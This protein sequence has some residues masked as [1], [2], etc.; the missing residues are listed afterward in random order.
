VNVISNPNKILDEY[1][2]AFEVARQESLKKMTTG[3][4]KEIAKDVKNTLAVAATREI[5]SKINEKVKAN[6]NLKEDENTF[7]IKVIKNLSPSS[8]MIAGSYEP[9]KDVI[10]PNRNIQTLEKFKEYEVA[11]IDEVNNKIIVKD[12]NNNEVKIDLK[13][14]A[15]D[16]Q[17][18]SKETQSFAKGD[19]IVFLQNNRDLKIFNGE[20]GYIKEYDK[21]KHI[22]KVEKEDG[23][24]V[25]FNPKLYDKFDLGYAI[26]AHKSQGTTSKKVVAVLDTKYK[27]MNTFNL[28]YVALSRHKEDVQVF[29]TNKQELKEQVQ[30]EQQKRS[31]LEYTQEDFDKETLIEDLKDFENLSKSEEE[32]AYEIAKAF[33]ATEEQKQQL[34]TQATKNEQKADKIEEKQQTEEQKQASH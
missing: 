24:I 15:L 18:Y 14:N 4:A 26:T 6:L 5:V 20:L 11:G 23:N 2:Q 8:K 30:K 17:V 21:E 10:I 32:K 22:L 19:K 16:L 12:K 28:A 3:A 25:E 27:D 29:T 1:K 13:E 34:Q 31:A 7:N 33:T 9:G